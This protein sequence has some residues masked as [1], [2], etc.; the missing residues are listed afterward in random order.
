MGGGGKL[1]PLKLSRMNSQVPANRA[2][3]MQSFSIRLCFMVYKK[4]KQTGHKN[5]QQLKNFQTYLFIYFKASVLATI[6]H[7][8]LSCHIITLLGRCPSCSVYI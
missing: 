4:Q 5:I 2:V 3:K 7:E 1:N 8:I 6:N